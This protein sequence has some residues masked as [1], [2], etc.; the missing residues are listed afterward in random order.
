MAVGTP[1]NQIHSPVC[2]IHDIPHLLHPLVSGL[3]ST[4]FGG[5]IPKPARVLDIGRSTWL[6]EAV[7]DAQD[8]QQQLPPDLLKE[9][10]RNLFA[11]T[12]SADGDVHPQ[13]ITDLLTQG[14]Q[15]IRVKTAEG[16]EVEATREKKK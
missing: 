9:L 4:T 2:G 15:S 16:S 7:R 11:S 13:A 3:G 8:K 10:S 1:H 5:R 6:L 12:S 14:L